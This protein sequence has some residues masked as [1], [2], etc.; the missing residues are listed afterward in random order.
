MGEGADPIRMFTA[1]SW[2]PSDDEVKGTEFLANMSK[3]PEEV[4][5]GSSIRMEMRLTRL[6]KTSS[7]AP[8]TGWKTRA[9]AERAE[10]EAV[11]K[12]AALV[13][14]EDQLTMKVQE[15]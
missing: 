11:D 1:F 13:E 4:L 14:A 7:D 6:L 5:K 2:R 9:V 3:M 15:E 12:M 8:E 10:A